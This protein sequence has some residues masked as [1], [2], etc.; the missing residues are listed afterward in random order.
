M[1]TIFIRSLLLV[2]IMGSSLLFAIRGSQRARIINNVQVDQNNFTVQ[3]DGFSSVFS[4]D[5]VIMNTILNN[6]E[7]KTERKHVRYFLRNFNIDNDYKK[8]LNVINEFNPGDIRAINAINA[9]ERSIMYCLRSQNYIISVENKWVNIF[10]LG[11]KWDWV[12]PK[13]WLNPVKWLTENDPMVTLCMNELSNVAKVAEK[14]SLVTS[15]RIKAKVD[16]YLHWK[17]NLMIAISTYLA[18][19][20]LGRGWKDSSVN[21][22]KVNGL[23]ST[24]NVI[25]QVRRDI[26]D[27]CYY[28]S[29]A[30]CTGSKTLADFIKPVV[31]TIVYG[32]KY[33][34]DKD[35]SLIA[36]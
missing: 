1:K 4:I 29:S 20:A 34:I 21:S 22:I 30:I 31:G 2:S 27:T 18:A 9:I 17:K 36:S 11:I 23:N 10:A 25:K 24:L 15:L 6:P 14:H 35:N 3:T 12:N 8:L 28:G 13:S 33:K 19:N 7:F 32:E 16:S 5:K 26:I